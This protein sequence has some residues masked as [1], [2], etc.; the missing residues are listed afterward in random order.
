M[1]TWVALRARGF[2]EQDV[3]YGLPATLFFVRHRRKP[4]SS[5]QAIQFGSG[6]PALVLWMFVRAVIDLE[7]EETMRTIPITAS[8]LVAVACSATSDRL[9]E[10]DT[11]TTEQAASAVDFFEAAFPNLSGTLSWSGESSN[12]TGGVGTIQPGTSP[13]IAAINGGKY[14]TAFQDVHTDAS[15]NHYLWIR[16]SDGTFANQ[17]LGMDSASSP[18]IAGLTSSGY[19]VAFQANNHNLY[20][21]GTLGYAQDQGL[22]MMPGTSPSI[23]ALPGNSWIAAMQANVGYLWIRAPGMTLP[24]VAEMAPSTSPSIAA[25]PDGSWQ[26]A[27][28]GID[29]TLKVYD[30][31]LGK[32]SKGYPMVPKTSP[33]IA[34][35]P[36]GGFEIAFQWQTSPNNLLYLDGPLSTG[37]TTLGPAPNTSPS[38]AVRADGK[39]EVAFVGLGTN[40][41]WFTGT[42]T[43]SKTTVKANGSPSVTALYPA[44]NLTGAPGSNST[45]AYASLSWTN[46]GATQYTGTWSCNNGTSGSKLYPAG[47]TSATEPQNWSTTC[48]Y[49]ITATY[50]NGWT[51]TS[52]SV[53][54]VT[55]SKPTGTGGASGTGGARATGGSSSV[56]NTGTVGVYY[57]MS[58]Y[59][60][61]CGSQSITGSLTPGSL[62]SNVSYGAETGF[63]NCPG[64]SGTCCAFYLGA[65]GLSAGNYTLQ[66]TTPNCTTTRTF[67]LSASSPTKQL[68]GYGAQCPN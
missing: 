26:V 12:P 25:Q 5:V 7:P 60:G 27:Y 20:V 67:S 48:N 4:P 68:Y 23:A 39:Y 24:W 32:V 13:S 21:T 56:F 11:G 66:V 35:V 55:R 45:G 34:A 31:R 65:S 47:T 29:N 36:G 10:Q 57:Y 59:R 15:G 17:Y 44:P 6:S 19:I 22:G 64:G 49:T 51:A 50:A 1:Q 16:M 2:G 9:S 18:S 43:S 3:W 8:I 61:T 53:P 28:Q 30:S 40:F 37:P 41:P 58:L 46:V 54:V 63:A 14:M 62:A 38:I 33:S 52:S 42:V